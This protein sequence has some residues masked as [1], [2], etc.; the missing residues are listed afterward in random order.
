KAKAEADAKA[1]A[2]AD[3]KAKAEADA[4]AK[5]EAD[6]KAKAEADAKAKAE[7]DAKAKAEADAKAK[8]MTKDGV[9]SVQITTRPSGA[10]VKGN[11][12]KFGK[13]PCTVSWDPGEKPPLVRIMKF[14]SPTVYFGGRIQLKETD[15]G[16][17]RHL[18]LVRRGGK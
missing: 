13:T 2:E 3:A 18:K 9:F 14:V 1:K 16:G 15:A 6:A 12:K 17:S 8:P 4:K 10:M 11:G 7:A 5:A